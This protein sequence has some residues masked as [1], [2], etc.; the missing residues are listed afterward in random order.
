MSFEAADL[1]GLA[2]QLAEAELDGVAVY[3]EAYGQVLTCLDPLGDEIH[4]DGRSDDLY[5]YREHPLAPTSSLR[6]SPVRFT[7]PQE[8]YCG[9]LQ[10][11]GP[12]S[13]G[14]SSAPSSR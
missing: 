5:G 9:F 14:R 3:D 8:P 10:A 4:V 1:T 12:R 13:R 11:L 7:D 6:V 2:K